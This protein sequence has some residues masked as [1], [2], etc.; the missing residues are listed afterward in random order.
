MTTLYEI[1]HP[2]F[3]YDRQ[4]I[5]LFILFCQAFACILIG[6]FDL[7]IIFKL[8][9]NFRYALT[10]CVIVFVLYKYVCKMK[11]LLARLFYIIELFIY[12]EQKTASNYHY[13][14]FF[15]LS[16]KCCCYFLFRI[17]IDVN[18]QKKLN[19]QSANSSCVVFQYMHWREK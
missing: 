8:R 19:F 10:F 3:S 11:C 12:K 13:Q 18:S 6:Y 17:E 2:F 5:V 14:S 7:C 15:R 4:C 9:F 1:R 16:N